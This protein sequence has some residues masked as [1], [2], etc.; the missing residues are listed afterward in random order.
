MQHRNRKES[1]DSGKFLNVELDKIDGSRYFESSIMIH[2]VG[3]FLTFQ[4]EGYVLVIIQLDWTLIERIHLEL[5]PIFA[6]S[7]Q[8][9]DFICDIFKD[10]WGNFNIIC[11]LFFLFA[12]IHHEI[13]DSSYI[14]C[15]FLPLSSC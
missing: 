10:E 12:L 5:L 1:D 13:Q 6:A 4:P 2:S 3:I 15:H 8:L 7:V 14:I 11:L 9:N